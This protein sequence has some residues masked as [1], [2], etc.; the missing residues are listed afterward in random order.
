[1]VTLFSTALH[2]GSSIFVTCLKTN[3]FRLWVDGLYACLFSRKNSE[4]VFP[5]LPPRGSI[6]TS[7]CKGRTACIQL[8]RTPPQLQSK[9]SGSV[10]G[11]RKRKRLPTLDKVF[12]EADQ[13]RSYC[14]LESAMKILFPLWKIVELSNVCVY[15]FLF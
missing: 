4:T 3:N 13:G 1:M 8:S 15:S 7:I 2:K 10:Q 5:E 11:Q 14:V 6:K 12:H 9:L